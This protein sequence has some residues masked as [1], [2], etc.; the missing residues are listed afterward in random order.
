MAMTVEELQVLITGETKQLRQ[1]L[2]QVKKQLSQADKDV[3]KATKSINSALKTIGATLATIGIGAFFASATKEAM[4]F[5]ASLQQINRLMGNSATTFQQWANT[6]ANAFGFARS[7]AVRY[8]AVY[9][10]LLSGFSSGTAETMQRTQDLLKTSAVVASSTGRTM[11]DVMER[12]R[13][14]LLGNTEA[15]NTPVAAA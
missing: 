4:Q 8:G 9:A 12:I 14:G 1:S 13:S 11:E 7:E 2:N 5:E 15:I 6:Q 10:N 3:G